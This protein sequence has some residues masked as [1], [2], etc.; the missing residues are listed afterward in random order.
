MAFKEKDKKNFLRKFVNKK[1]KTIINQFFIRKTILSKAK[2][3]N[4]ANTMS[5]YNNVALGAE[6]S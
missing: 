5:K 6:S 4:N 1:E 3:N 2:S